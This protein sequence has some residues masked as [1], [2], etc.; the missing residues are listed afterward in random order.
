MSFISCLLFA[1]TEGSEGERLNTSSWFSA[2]LHRHFCGVPARPRQLYCLA[3]QR[4]VMFNKVALKFES[5]ILQPFNTS[6]FTFNWRYDWLMLIWWKKQVRDPLGWPIFPPFSSLS[7]SVSPLQPPHVGLCCCG[8]L[9]SDSIDWSGNE[10]QDRLLILIFAISTEAALRKRK[11]LKNG[12][13]QIGLFE[14]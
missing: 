2:W 6:R 3:E 8:T 10:S 14:P 7:L 1:L 11:R 12:I 13:F 9:E 5:V 4:Q